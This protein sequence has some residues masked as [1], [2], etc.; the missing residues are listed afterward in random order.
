MIRIVGSL[1][2]A[3]ITSLDDNRSAIGRIGRVDAGILDEELTPRAELTQVD[4]QAYSRDGLTRTTGMIAR[5]TEALRCRALGNL[6]YAF[7]AVAESMTIYGP[8][9]CVR[10]R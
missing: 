10:I 1:E 9:R 2:A 4:R 3:H 5:R 7:L 6:E 8:G